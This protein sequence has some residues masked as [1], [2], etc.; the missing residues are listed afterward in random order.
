MQF[1]PRNLQSIVCSH[2]FLRERPVLLV[3][4]DQGDW[5]FMCG[6]TDHGD[7]G[8]VVSVGHLVDEDASLHECADLPIGFEAERS[9]VVSLGLGC[10]SMQMSALLSFQR[11]AFGVR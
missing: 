10:A 8:H 9:A 2:V 4:H 7:D 6:G 11:T 3:V 5:Q 1:K